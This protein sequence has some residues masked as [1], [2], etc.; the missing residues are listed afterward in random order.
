MTEHDESEKRPVSADTGLFRSPVTDDGELRRV[1]HGIRERG[2]IGTIDLDDAIEHADRYVALLPHSPGRLADLGSG[3]GLPGLVI[4]V[5]RP[6]LAVVLV[7]R[8][9]TRAD[10]LRR[11]V[12]ALRLADRVT[13]HADD[14]RRLAEMESGAFDVVTARSFAAP[15]VT[16]EWAGRLLRSGGVLLVSEPPGEG[17]DLGASSKRWPSDVLARHGLEPGD[18]VAGIRRIHRR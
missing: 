15:L 12:S 2:G 5:R 1:L 7:E 13:V 6:D 3:G 11:A 8:R 17:L 18:V 10:L 16:A 4:A 9:L 14:V